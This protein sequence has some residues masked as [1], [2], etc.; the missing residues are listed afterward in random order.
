MPAQKRFELP[1]PVLLCSALPVTSQKACLPIQ[2]EG[3]AAVAVWHGAST[4]AGRPPLTSGPYVFLHA[5]DSL[6]REEWQDKGFMGRL[7][8][9]EP[10][11]IAASVNIRLLLFET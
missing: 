6:R 2:H 8:P 11:D 10:R 1:L 3:Q 5:V 7:S 4:F 9:N